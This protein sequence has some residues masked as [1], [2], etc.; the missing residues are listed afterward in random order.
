MKVAWKRS[1]GFDDE[2]IFPGSFRNLVT[3]LFKNSPES[4]THLPRPDHRLESFNIGV[5]ERRGSLTIRRFSQVAEANQSAALLIPKPEGQR[6]E[7]GEEGDGRDGL[8]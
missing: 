6:L 3:R 1:G 7:T 5:T 4:F 8:E 2:S